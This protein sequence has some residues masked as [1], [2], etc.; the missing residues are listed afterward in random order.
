[1]TDYNTENRLKNTSTM[2]S[3]QNFQLNKWE[4]I[5]IRAPGIP[6][7]IFVTVEYNWGINLA[8]LEK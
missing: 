8:I 6:W 5:E 7:V 3:E 1:M 2:V 4:H